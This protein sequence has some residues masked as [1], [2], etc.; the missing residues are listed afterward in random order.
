M[1]PYEIHKSWAYFRILTWYATNKKQY[2]FELTNR[3]KK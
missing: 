1:K 3:F 2:N